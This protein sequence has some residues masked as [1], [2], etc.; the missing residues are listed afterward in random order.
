MTEV[1]T[2]EKESKSKII[3]AL[4]ACDEFCCGEGPYQHLDDGIHSLKCIH[5]LVKDV[6][7]LLKQD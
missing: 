6:Y 2:I 1:K 4:R 3:T 7:K 5:T